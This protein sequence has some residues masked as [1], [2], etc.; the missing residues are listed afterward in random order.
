MTDLKFCKKMLSLINNM[1]NNKLK[2]KILNI[3]DYIK[4][5]INKKLKN[6]INLSKNL[7]TMKV[8]INQLT[9]H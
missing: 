7:K 1:K 6:L 3:G 5:I 2:E 4:E 9:I 8:M